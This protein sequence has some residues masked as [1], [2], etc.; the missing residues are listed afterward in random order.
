MKE[1][2]HG[3]GKMKF[4]NSDTYE[5]SWSNDE[6]HGVGV[7]YFGMTKDK[8]EG[9]WEKGKREGKGEY[10]WSNGDKL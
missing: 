6:K 4:I 5:G 1:K 7:Y 9:N 10:I 2:R 8:F 3:Y